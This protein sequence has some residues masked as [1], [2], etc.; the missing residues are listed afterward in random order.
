MHA[1]AYV[2]RITGTRALKS[3]PFSYQ[4]LSVVT[5]KGP[6]DASWSP[7]GSVHMNEKSNLICHQHVDSFAFAGI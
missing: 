6:E 7:V 4:W 2:A 5:P 3:V 1:G